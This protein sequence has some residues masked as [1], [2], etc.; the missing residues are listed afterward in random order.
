MSIVEKLRARGATVYFE[1]DATKLDRHKDLKKLTYDTVVFNF[2]HVGASGFFQYSGPKSDWEL[3][4]KIALFVFAQTGAGIK[5]Q[6]RNIVINQK[7]LVDFFQSTAPLLAKGKD[8]S[9]TPGSSKQ[10]RRKV[11]DGDSDE[12]ADSGVSDLEQ[13]EALDFNPARKPPETRGTVLITLRDAAPYTLWSVCDLPSHF[14]PLNKTR[15]HSS[16]LI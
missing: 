4:P 14:I 6:D 16:H 13:E 2:P 10:K 15:L 3:T 9:S 7:L 12:D 11:E 5:D 8:P 1:V